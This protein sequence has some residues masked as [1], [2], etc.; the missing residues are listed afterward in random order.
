MKNY[1]AALGLFAAGALTGAMSVGFARGADAQT[2]LDLPIKVPCTAA[3][4]PCTHTFPDDVPPTRPG[5]VVMPAMAGGEIYAP[6][7][8]KKTGHLK[9]PVIVTLHNGDGT[10]WQSITI[11]ERHQ[12]KTCKAQ[13]SLHYCP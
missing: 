10:I 8:K 11:K 9:P 1:L 4:L 5:A 6:N 2:G 13:A 12:I 3:T 7:S